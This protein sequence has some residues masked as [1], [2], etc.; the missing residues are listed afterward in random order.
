MYLADN[1]LS[2]IQKKTTGG[3]EFFL[4]KARI[5]GLERTVAAGTVIIATVRDVFVDRQGRSIY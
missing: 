3:R 4:A 5:R 2:Q 1:T